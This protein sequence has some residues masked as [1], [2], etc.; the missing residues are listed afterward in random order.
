MFYT[1]V[2]NF[3]NFFKN[4]KT[5]DLNFIFILCKDF[6]FLHCFLNHL[7]MY[8]FGN[9]LVFFVQINTTL[10]TFTQSKTIFL[11]L[12]SF[13]FNVTRNKISNFFVCDY[14]NNNFET[15]VF[16]IISFWGK[17]HFNMKGLQC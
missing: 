15:N 1:F 6:E 4:L 13:S 2:L 12:N 8:I 3:T 17:N 9:K 5:F 16:L 11:G 7:K 14:Y 10:S